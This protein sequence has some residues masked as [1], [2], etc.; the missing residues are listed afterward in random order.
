MP[1]RKLDRYL[2]IRGWLLLLCAGVWCHIG[3]GV[4]LE[5]DSRPPVYLYEHLPIW[6]RVGGWWITGALA[7]WA[8]VRKTNRTYIAVAGLMIMPLERLGSLLWGALD[9][10]LHGEPAALA[11]AW[12]SAG[13]YVMLVGVVAIT[14]HV[15]EPTKDPGR[16]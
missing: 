9:Y 13:W 1:H 14:A 5:P 8:A 4:L 6:M 15:K 3:L 7:L 2:G 10:A 12:Y 16:H 11:T